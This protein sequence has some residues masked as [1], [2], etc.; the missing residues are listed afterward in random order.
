MPAATASISIEEIRTLRA[1]DVMT[2]RPVTVAPATPLSEVQALMETRGIVHFPV[3]EDERLVA[4][5][6]ERELRDAMPSVVTVDDPEARRR[7]LKVTRVSQV[8]TKSPPVAAPETPILDLIARMRGH[9]AGA[10]PIVD[11]GRLVGIVSAGDLITLLE[12]LLRSA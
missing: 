6:D 3:V 11:N 5:L 7:F 9:R 1:R 4:L 12:R 8:A 10:L 2:P